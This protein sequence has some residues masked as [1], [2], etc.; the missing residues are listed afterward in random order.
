[1]S[2]MDRKITRILFYLCWLGFILEI[3]ILL[4]KTIKNS[5]LFIAL[6]S[7]FSI[8]MMIVL[9]FGNKQTERIK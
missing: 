6:W 3:F 1:M 2:S 5:N 7:L 8:L 9:F 4:S